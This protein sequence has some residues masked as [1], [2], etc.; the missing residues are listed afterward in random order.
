MSV[1]I[2]KSYNLKTYNL[3]F[4]KIVQISPKEDYL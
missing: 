1:F 4:K 3:L 2:R